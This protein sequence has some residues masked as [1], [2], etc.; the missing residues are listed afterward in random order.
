M[1]R[2]RVIDKDRGF[3]KLLKQVRVIDRTG[4]T[5]GVHSDAHPYP[6]G[7]SVITVAEAQEFGVPSRNIEPR[8]FVS[9]YADDKSRSFA[10]DARKFIERDLVSPI[11]NV[12]SSLKRLALQMGGEMQSSESVPIDT[13][14]LRQSITGRVLK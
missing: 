8:G 11:G 7:N 10:R 3:K 14:H 13:G 4:V 1:A 9:G 2:V 6:N 12:E 5:V